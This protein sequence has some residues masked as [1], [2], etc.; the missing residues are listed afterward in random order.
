MPLAEGLHGFPRLEIQG[1]AVATLVSASIILLFTVWH[2]NNLLVGLLAFVW[3]KRHITN[4]VNQSCDTGLTP[5]RNIN[6]Y[7]FYSPALQIRNQ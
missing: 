3:L 4:S 5:W 1:A 6:V 7:C 2:L